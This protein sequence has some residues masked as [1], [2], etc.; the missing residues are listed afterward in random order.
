MKNQDTIFERH[1]VE[2]IA[3]GI[4]ILLSIIA[5]TTLVDPNTAWLIGIFSAS[6]AFAVAIL[7]E[8][9]SGKTSKLFRELQKVI[10][11]V[12]SINQKMTTAIDV[13]AEVEGVHLAH[14][15]RE[16]DGFLD[17]LKKN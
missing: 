11:E 17:N 3:G 6:L 16:L 10:L 2:I 14:A 4:G 15:S 9:F 7:K 1:L 5:G 12:S 8:Y 13:F